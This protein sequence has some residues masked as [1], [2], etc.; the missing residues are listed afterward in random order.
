MSS[1]ELSFPPQALPALYHAADQ[2]SLKKQQSYLRLFLCVLITTSAAPAVIILGALCSSLAQPARFIAAILLVTSLLITAKIK[3]SQRERTWYGARAVAES[4]KTSAWRF[5][6]AADP[7]PVSLAAPAAQSLFQTTLNE[8]LKD[9]QSLNYSSA[10][11]TNSQAQITAQ[12]Q[13]LRNATWQERLQ[14]YVTDRV[15]DQRHWYAKKASDSDSRESIYF[16]VILSSQLASVVAAAAF[17]AWPTLHI[18]LAAI[19]TAGTASLLAWLQVKRYQETAQSYALAAQELGIIEAGA[20]TVTSEQEF[21]KFVADAENAMSREHT[22]W[23][24]KKDAK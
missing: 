17:A 16:W 1:P 10:G 11:E 22:L 19:F 5:A 9:R 8:I 23:V 24:A 18:N 3:D 15:Q 7:F 13:S 20:A 14:T 6:M 2:T 21:A 4:V 12:M